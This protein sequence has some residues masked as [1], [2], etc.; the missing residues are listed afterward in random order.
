MEKKTILIIVAVVAVAIIAIGAM[1]AIG[2]AKTDIEYNYTYELTDSFQGESTVMKADEGKQ[3]VIFNVH[4]KNIN[5]NETYTT[6]PLTW[7]WKAQAN[8]LQYTFSSWNTY[9]HPDYKLVDFTPGS[10]VR[11]TLVFEIPDDVKKSDI[12]FTSEYLFKKVDLE[13]NLS[14]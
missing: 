9:Q 14:L 1:A 12:T 5:S 7:Q 8:G 2:S 6:N 11:Y 10:D 3:F 4:A 13:R